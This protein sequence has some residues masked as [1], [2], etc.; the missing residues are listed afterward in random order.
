MAAYCTRRENKPGS[1]IVLFTY[2]AGLAYFIFKLVRMYQPGHEAQYL[3]VRNSLTVFAAITI[4]L[5]T[6][7]IA[8][9][10]VCLNNYNRGLLPYVKQRKI[11]SEEE[12]AAGMTELNDVSKHGPSKI[13]MEID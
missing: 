9:S 11:G 7:T 8:N 4:L 12:K 10:I 5:I 1:I 6:G 2:V 13:R 3:P